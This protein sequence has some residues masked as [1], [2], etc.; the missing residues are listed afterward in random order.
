M[1]PGKTQTRLPRHRQFTVLQNRRFYSFGFINKTPRNFPAL[2]L[3]FSSYFSGTSSRNVGDQ[4]WYRNVTRQAAV[5]EIEQ[6]MQVYFPDS[7]F[8]RELKIKL[9]FLENETLKQR[10]NLYAADNE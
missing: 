7:G 8:N 4:A 6:N 9:L 2:P 10:F 5:Q 3:H 1:Q